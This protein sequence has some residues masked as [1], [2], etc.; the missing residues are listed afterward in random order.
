MGA[1]IQA[2]SVSD[3]VGTT[4]DEASPCVASDP[5]A[6]A[7]GLYGNHVSDCVGTTSDEASPCVASDPPAYAGGLYGKEIP[8]R[9]TS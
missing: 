6:H 3:C 9:I 7:E 5:P 2:R 4:I 1:V 8:A